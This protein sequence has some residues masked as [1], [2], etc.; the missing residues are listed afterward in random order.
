MSKF[1]FD[2][3][4]RNL[5][6]AKRTLPIQLAN[7]ARVYFT[8]TF[9]VGGFDGKKWKEVQ[10][11]IPGTNAYKYP[12]KKGL[13]RRTK[14]ILVQYGL[15]RRATSM[16]VRTKNFKKISLVVDLKYAANHNDGITVPKRQFMGR[17]KEL[18]RKHRETIKK[19]IGKIWQV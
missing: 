6:G 19:V 18:D 11:R 9:K 3:I 2:K 16:S 1:G 5:D 15:L 4:L 14:P 13:S 12:K 7:E 10:R 8:N 17:S